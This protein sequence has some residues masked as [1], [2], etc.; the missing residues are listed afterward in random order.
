MTSSLSQLSFMESSRGMT[1]ENGSTV[2][3]PQQPRTALLCRKG[4]AL[5]EGL[6]KEHSFLVYSGLAQGLKGGGGDPLS[7]QKRPTLEPGNLFWGTSWG[8]RLGSQNRG[9]PKILAR[10]RGRARSGEPHA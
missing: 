6:G 2:R 8:S 4:C 1:R 5:E 3:A 10:R 7:P 9:L